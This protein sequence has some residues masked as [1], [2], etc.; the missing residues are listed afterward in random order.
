ML[1]SLWGSTPFAFASVPA[2]LNRLRDG[3]DRRAAA[4]ELRLRAQDTAHHEALGQGLHI[5]VGALACDDVAVRR[6]A[7]EA[8]SRSCDRAGVPDERQWVELVNA[9]ALVEGEGRLAAVIA[10]LA[11]GD[12]WVRWWALQL[13]RVLCAQDAVLPAVRAAVLASSEGPRLVADTLKDPREAV[14]AQAVALLA[15]LVHHCFALA[16]LA[17]YGGA[18]EDLLEV[19]ATSGGLEAGAVLARDALD[20]LAR[21]LDGNS[22]NKQHFVVS[23]LAARLPALLAVEASDYMVLVDGKAEAL[24]A[25]CRL[26]ATL[27]QPDTPATRDAQQALAGPVFA[28]LATLGLTRLPSHAVRAAALE[29]LAAC[30]R[31]S[32][33]ACKALQLL[34]VAVDGGAAAASDPLAV[35]RAVRIAL[36]DGVHAAEGQAA[37]RLLEAWLWRNSAAQLL[38]ATQLSQPGTAAAQLAAAATSPKPLHAWAACHVLAAALRDCPPAQVTALQTGTALLG[39]LFDAPGGARPDRTAQVAR[40]RLAYAWC[41]AP[42]AVAAV[43][44]GPTRVPALVESVLSPAAD[45]HVAAHAAMLLLRLQAHNAPTRQVLVHRVGSDKLLGAFRSAMRTRDWDEGSGAVTTAA[46]AAQLQLYAPEW[47]AT[48]RDEYEAAAALLGDGAAAFAAKTTPAAAEAL[49]LR[50][51]LAVAEREVAELK[52][53]AAA[54]APLLAAPVPAAPAGS[55]DALVARDRDI[56]DLKRRVSELEARNAQLQAENDR[57]LVML[58]D[59]EMALSNK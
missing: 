26:V 56:A 16:Q 45:P 53:A 30:V 5:L 40:L 35:E 43:L 22:S 19:Y 32:A 20:C 48:L 1:A 13:L 41:E 6:A 57:L 12:V 25:A 18:F 52:R 37:A 11:D 17:A 3:P 15:V 39:A 9:E 4:D 38:V 54:A 24:A 59:Q 49:R 33:A 36:A 28:A 58:A 10:A 44:A 55:L 23:G 50:A 31:G 27:V 29:A 2:A 14:S 42:E 8:L 7:L 47:R 51:A 21:L 46:A 34:R